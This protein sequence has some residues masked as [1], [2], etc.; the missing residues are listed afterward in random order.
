MLDQ[1]HISGYIDEPLLEENPLIYVVF[2]KRLEGFDWVIIQIF[3]TI[4]E[5]F[6]S[7]NIFEFSWSAYIVIRSHV[8]ILV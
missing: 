1:F 7:E 3:A 6:N 8:L 5:G 4:S 2:E